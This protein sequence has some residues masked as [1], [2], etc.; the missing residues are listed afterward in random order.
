MAPSAI[1]VICKLSIFACIIVHCAASHCPFPGIPKH[2]YG[3]VNGKQLD[4]KTNPFFEKGD[5]IDFKCFDNWSTTW[6][7]NS[8][9]KCLSNG[10]W[11]SSL[12]QCRNS[13]QSILNESKT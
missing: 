11:N 7:A 6:Q 1:S 5:V 3:T 2:G 10:M 4:L 12:P 9:I 8:S 13:F